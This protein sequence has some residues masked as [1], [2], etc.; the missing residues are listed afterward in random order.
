MGNAS[1]WPLSVAGTDIGPPASR[2][3]ARPSTIAD[4]GVER[5]W[6]GSKPDAVPG[7][8]SSG[9]SRHST[10]SGTTERIVRVTRPSC[11]MC[12]ISLDLGRAHRVRSSWPMRE[13][14]ET[15]HCEAA[16]LLPPDYGCRSSAGAKLLQLASWRPPREHRW[17]AENLVSLPPVGALEVL[18]RKDRTN[19]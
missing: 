4:K 1:R 12:S 15:G 16:N 2:L 9:V 11:F 6:R 18:V 19:L 13:S 17:R 14:E 8:R 7:K 5:G 10:R 3:P